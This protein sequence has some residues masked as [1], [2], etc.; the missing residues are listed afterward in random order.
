MLN[1]LIKT[2]RKLV[3]L[4]SPERGYFGRVPTYGQRPKKYEFIGYELSEDFLPTLQ[5]MSESQRKNLIDIMNYF[6]IHAHPLRKLLDI[7]QEEQLY[8]FYSKLAWSHFMTVVMFGMLEMATKGE[9]G[10]QLS[11]KH[12][13]MKDFLEENLPE[14]IKES[15][16]E[17]YSV[18]E[19]SDYEEEI[20]SFSDVV[21]HLWHQIRSGFIHDAGVESKGLEWHEL[22]G[23]GTKDDPITIKSD[24]PM[25]EWLQITWQAIL[26][27][28]GYTGSLDLLKYKKEK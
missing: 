1:D 24:V 18:E 23:V 9:R 26:N 2:N 25:Q 27:S 5:N 16:V 19:I 7:K 15:I 3:E 17:R 22:T 21:D 13:R 8:K 14:E 11:R 6:E 4:L 10:V 12:Q 28:Y 20:E